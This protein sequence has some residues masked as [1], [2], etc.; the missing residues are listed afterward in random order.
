MGDRN[1]FIHKFDVD[2]LTDADKDTAWRARY[3][4]AKVSKFEGA[5]DAIEAIVT[6]SCLLYTSPS[7]RDDT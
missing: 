4:G 2:K 7:P 6:D 3:G 5:K 1:S